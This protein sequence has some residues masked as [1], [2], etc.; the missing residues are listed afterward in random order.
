MRAICVEE[1]RNNAVFALR[2]GLKYIR[3]KNYVAAESC[4]EQAFKQ[5]TAILDKQYPKE[6]TE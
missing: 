6:D 1:L 5:L 4:A 2:E 3:Q